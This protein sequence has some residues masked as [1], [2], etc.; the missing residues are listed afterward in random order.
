MP[1]KGL[2]KHFYAF[3]KDFLALFTSLFARSFL[4]SIKTLL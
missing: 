4:K 1:Y 3:L 2:F